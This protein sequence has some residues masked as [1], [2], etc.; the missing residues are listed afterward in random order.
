[1]EDF[2]TIYQCHRS[3]SLHDDAFL[4]LKHRKYHNIGPIKLVECLNSLKKVERIT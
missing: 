2:A 1:M 4:D 3:N